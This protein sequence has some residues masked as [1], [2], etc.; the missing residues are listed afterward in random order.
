MSDA[1][2]PIRSAARTGGPGK[3]GEFTIHVSPLAA[4]WPMAWLNALQ[5]FIHDELAIM[6]SGEH[7]IRPVQGT[8]PSQDR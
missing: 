5:S 7:F 4:P 6:T 2:D 3:R 1:R 8:G